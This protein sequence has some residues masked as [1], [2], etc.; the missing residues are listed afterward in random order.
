MSM[1]FLAWVKGLRAR[2]DA[3]DAALLALAEKVEALEVEV[4]EHAE[5]IAMLVDPGRKRA[6]PGM[7]VVNG[8]S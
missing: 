8:K 6:N 2:Q 1:Q 4:A 7:K 3:A 5:H